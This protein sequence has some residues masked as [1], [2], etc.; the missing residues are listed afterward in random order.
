MTRFYKLTLLFFCFGL[1][2][3]LKS[4]LET[5]EIIN[6]LTANFDLIIISIFSFLILIGAFIIALYYLIKKI[7]RREIDL[8]KNDEATVKQI[9]EVITNQK[10]IDEI[11]LND[12]LISTISFGALWFIRISASQFYLHLV[13]TLVGG[14]IGIATLFRQRYK[15]MR[16]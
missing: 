10:K 3:I 9:V 7:I 12:R 13:V 14:L 5:E 8:P 2:F 11:E 16:I 6:F 4:L 15:Q 1:G